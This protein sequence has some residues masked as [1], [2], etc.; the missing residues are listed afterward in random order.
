MKEIPPKNTIYIIDQLL[1]LAENRFHITKS[2][3]YLALY[4]LTLKM[5]SCLN[6]IAILSRNNDRMLCVPVNL[7]YRCMITDLMTALLVSIVDD[8]TFCKVMNIMDIGYANSLKK[9][10]YAE[11]KVKK[12]I[13]PEKETAFDEAAQKYQMEHYEDFKDCL[14]SQEG[15]PWNV[16][17][18]EKMYINNVPFSD[19]IDSIYKVL[20]T[21]NDVKDIASIYKY[22]K[23]FSQSEH[24]SLRNRVFIYK[25]DFHDMYYN[26]VRGLVYLG[27]DYIYKRYRD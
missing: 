11:I 6:A 7:L 8:E 1:Q 13:C 19:N 21:F 22:Y 17:S 4:D 27:V 18:K 5:K 12:S 2:N 9:A 20:L 10:I 3:R 16:K 24:F 26:K 25:Q 23:L 14:K 15:E